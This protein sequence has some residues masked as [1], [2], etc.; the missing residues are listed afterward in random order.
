MSKE[1]H[2]FAEPLGRP[3]KYPDTIQKARPIAAVLGPFWCH[4]QPLLNQN[5]LLLDDR[6]RAAASTAHVRVD[7]WR[8]RRRHQAGP[9]TGWH[10]HGKLELMRLVV[11]PRR[12]RFFFQCSC[13]T[14]FARHRSWQLPWLPPG[15]P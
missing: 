13:V 4:F 5:W 8:V 12:C 9:G 11:M 14:F 15:C 6:A 1:Q 3:Q 10:E 7:V 2:I